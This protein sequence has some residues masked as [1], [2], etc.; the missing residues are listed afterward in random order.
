MSARCSIT[1]KGTRVGNKVSHSNIK[2]KRKFN[3]N[4]QNCSVFSE[5]LKTSVPMKI[6]VSTLRTIEHNGG[7]DEYLLTTSNRKLS[8]E[9]I[10]L[11]KKIKKAREGSKAAS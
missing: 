5:T 4:L 11:K 1:Q 8:A 10:T 3:V 9:A 2:T 7:L 6:A